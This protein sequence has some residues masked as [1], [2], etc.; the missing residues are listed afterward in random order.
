MFA[1]RLMLNRTSQV[2]AALEPAPS[3]RVPSEK[4]IA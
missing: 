1:G 2:G 3:D 4:P